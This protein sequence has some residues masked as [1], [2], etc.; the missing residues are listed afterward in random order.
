MPKQDTRNNMRRRFTVTANDAKEK[1]R[2]LKQAYILKTAVLSNN[3]WKILVFTIIVLEWCLFQCIS[4]I[5]ALLHKSH[6]FTDTVPVSLNLIILRFCNNRL[7]FF[8]YTCC[9]IIFLMINFSNPK[10]VAAVNA[11]HEQIFVGNYLQQ[12]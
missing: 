5:I 3:K 6:H 10:I 1:D 2:Q 12:P 4:I 11:V 9:K 8:G 7:Q